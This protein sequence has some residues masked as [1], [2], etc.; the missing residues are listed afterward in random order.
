MKNVKIK[1]ETEEQNLKVQKRVHELNDGFAWRVY[2]DNGYDYSDSQDFDYTRAVW[3]RWKKY[4][5]LVIDVDVD[6]IICI[7]GYIWKQRKEKEVSFEEF[8]E[9]KINNEL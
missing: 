3:S 6:L 5:Y 4:K 2:L 8:M 9:R 7:N 1:V